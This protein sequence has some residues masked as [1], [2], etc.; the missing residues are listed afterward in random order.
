[1]ALVRILV[2]GYSLLHN[3]PELAPGRARH[4][5]AAREELIQ[6]LTRYQDASHTP[7]TVFF[8]GTGAKRKGTADEF[9]RQVEVLFSGTG[10]TADDLIERAAYRFREYGEV[11]VVTDD[12][13]ER[14]TITGL[15][16]LTASCASFLQ[17]LG[18][19]ETQLNQDLEQYNRRERANYRRPK[20]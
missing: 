10:Q 3:W 11:L 18:Q 4:S 9:A 16:G 13:A 7:V 1:M 15:G 14:D 2:D 6:W 20:H 17:M 12:L 5:A 8:D 19:V